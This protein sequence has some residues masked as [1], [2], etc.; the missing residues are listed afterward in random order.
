MTK[1]TFAYIPSSHLD[2]Y[3]LGNY[4]TC[5][6]R[7]AE[8][9]RQ[10]VERC[11]EHP[12][13]TFFIETTVFAN[14]FCERH[15][16]LAPVL[17]QLAV[18]GR[19]E[20]GSAFVDRWETLVPAEAL[21]RNVLI[22]KEFCRRVFGMDNPTVTHPDLPSMTPQI[23]QIYRQAGLHYYV[24]SRKVFPNGQVWR[25]RS[26]DGSTLLVLNYPRH[27]V[28]SLIDYSD[29]PGDLG[30]RLWTAPFDLER[31]LAGFPLGSVAVSG[32]AG[33]LTDRQSFLDRYGRQLEEYVELYRQKYPDYEF[34]YT[35]PSRVLAPYL[36][37][38]DLPV[39]SGSIP[40][41]WGVAADEEVTFFQRDRQIEAR[42]LTAETL[43][44][45]A[46]RLGLDWL[47]EQA[48]LWQGTFN[49]NAFFARKD[50]IQPGQELA[51]LWRM[52]I[53]TQ[54]HNG[55]GQEGA[56]STFQK[57]V[58]QQR[59]L[60]YTGQIIDTVLDRMG[61]RVGVA[62]L[63][64]FNP[65]AQDWSALGGE[66]LAVPVPVD[67]APDQTLAEEEA[68]TTPVQVG[69]DGMLY[70]LPE[71]IPAV[72]YQIFRKSGA[73]Q[74]DPC[75]DSAAVSTGPAALRLQ[76]RHVTLT[77]DLRAGNLTGLIDRAS[78]QDWGNPWLGALSVVKESGNDV[79]LR[80]APDAPREVEELESV[81]VTESGPLFARIEVKKRLLG[82]DVVQTITLWNHAPRVDLHTR[83]L[84][85]G[86][87]NCQVRLGMPAGNNR[88]EITCGAPFY[89]AGWMDTAE[90][91]LP[92]NGDEISPA[93]QMAY[94]EVLGWL[95]IRRGEA[96][97]S[98]FSAHPGF[99]QGSDGL[100]AVL[101]RT[102]PS[103]GDGRLF[104]ENAGEQHFHFVLRMGSG[105]WQ[106]DA[107]PARAEAFLRPPAARWVNPAAEAAP[108]L[109][110]RD[111]F[112]RASEGA[113]LSSLYPGQCGQPLTRLWNPSGQPAA[114][115]L[116]G[117]LVQGG[118]R[119]CDFLENPSSA[120]AGQDG[121]W[122]LT[123]PPWSIQTILL[124]PGASR[125]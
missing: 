72:G 59:C 63:L 114:V 113:I 44:V 21:I 92:Y 10:Y 95:H 83:L 33:D 88:A 18:E 42:L 27:Y 86:A 1:P 50:P 37:Y 121:I 9:I 115:Q 67:W 109:P 74:E 119:A 16:H 6:E 4:K 54:D 23:A 90:G 34:A 93:D 48:A 52:H 105:D 29:A 32:S 85:W 78:G 41:V 14:Y 66:P 25:Y 65:H 117:S 7:G 36:D 111:S 11:Q 60:Q 55:G 73:Q 15:P 97:L 118:A 84:W 30:R 99:Y 47:P 20:V 107:V 64:V 108:T 62:G 89:G 31:T 98:I 58:I 61:E 56:L 24:T 123:L 13:E 68:G 38:P 79:S 2:L 102:V 76:N 40:S 39:L 26:P 122:A 124:T 81:W 43:A 82:C 57:R 80:I 103:C 75:I 91:T 28:F 94:R 120:L 3:W 51:E 53:F 8:I 46:R 110:A 49:E 106:A 77:V 45:V 22:G 101:M 125:E 35:T 104:W 112:F 17:K 96:G 19:V 5:L 12:D 69:A 116:S 100:S 70:L 71:T 87:H